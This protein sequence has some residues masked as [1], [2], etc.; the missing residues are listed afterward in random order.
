VMLLLLLGMAGASLAMAAPAYMRGELSWPPA[1]SPAAKQTS[2]HVLGA[3][4][5]GRKGVLVDTATHPGLVELCGTAKGLVVAGEPEFALQIQS[6]RLTSPFVIVGPFTMA[7]ELDRV[8]HT[9]P[10]LYEHGAEGYARIYDGAGLRLY[11]RI[12]P[13]PAS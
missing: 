8:A 12:A 10:D 1:I 2:H 4:L 9:F 3:A 5:C 13:E 6:R 11:A 7:A